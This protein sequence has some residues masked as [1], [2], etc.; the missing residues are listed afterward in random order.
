MNKIVR[1]T[2]ELFDYE[3]HLTFN[4]M[5]K[6]LFGEEARVRYIVLCLIQKAIERNK[7]CTPDLVKLRVGLSDEDQIFLSEKTQRHNHKY[8]QKSHFMVSLVDCGDELTPIELKYTFD[9]SVLKRVATAMGG[10]LVSQSN[11]YKANFVL[12]VPCKH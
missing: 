7:A 8:L 3:V 2:Y 1:D 10:K 6:T 11:K 5:P 12:M 4:K 9:T